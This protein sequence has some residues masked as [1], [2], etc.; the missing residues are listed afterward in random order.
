MDNHPRSCFW[1]VLPIFLSVYFL[2]SLHFLRKITHCR[3][4]FVLC[5][6]YLAIY[7]RRHSV[8]VHGDCPILHTVACYFT[9]WRCCS[10]FRPTFNIYM[11]KC[12]M[13][14]YILP[15]SPSR[16]S[17]PVCILSHVRE[18]LFLQSLTKSM[19]RHPFRFSPI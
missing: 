15:N 7:P 2:I 11:G 8:S 14:C 10:L 12:V 4:S 16:R 5:F 17:V 9:V 13:L 6:L 3:L 18:C 19:C 1:F